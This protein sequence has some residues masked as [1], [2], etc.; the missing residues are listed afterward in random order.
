MD[1]LAAFAREA[2]PIGAVSVRIT[3]SRVRLRPEQD[4]TWQISADPQR[5]GCGGG[6]AVV[7]MGLPA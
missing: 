7:G 3:N 4:P 2:L 1:W 6:L 5:D